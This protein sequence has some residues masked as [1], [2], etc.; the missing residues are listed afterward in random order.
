MNTLNPVPKENYSVRPYASFTSGLVGSNKLFK[1]TKLAEFAVF[2]LIINLQLR[3]R[4]YSWYLRPRLQLYL[5]RAVS[6]AA[7]P[8]YLYWYA[9]RASFL[10]TM[11]PN[12]GYTVWQNFFCG[13]VYCPQKPI[14]SQKFTPV[15]KFNTQTAES[16]CCHLKRL[17]R[18]EAKLWIERPKVLNWEEHLQFCT[19][20]CVTVIA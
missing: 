3:K 1:E 6:L 13:F 14:T 18:L 19:R 5:D 16:C 15:A 4:H 11:E 8:S 12:N 20:A 9:T 2:R 7:L 17:F 10:A